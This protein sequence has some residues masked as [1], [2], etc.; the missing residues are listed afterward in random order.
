MFRI[1]RAVT[2]DFLYLLLV[3]S[4][5]LVNTRYPAV[6]FA[7]RILQI[8]QLARLSNANAV[9]FDQTWFRDFWQKRIVFRVQDYVTLEQDWLA[10][11][12]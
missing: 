10:S 12:G 9:D 1:N 8:F 7:V 3:I 4:L 11:I 5:I 6:F 2:D